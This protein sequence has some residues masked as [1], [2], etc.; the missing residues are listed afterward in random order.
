[1]LI[2][3]PAFNPAKEVAAPK[4]T[5]GL[6][7][8]FTAAVLSFTDQ[9]Q[10]KCVSVDCHVPYE[11]K[12]IPLHEI[13]LPELTGSQSLVVIIMGMR[14]YRS[15]ENVIDQMRWKLMVVVGSFYN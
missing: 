6:Q 5:T 11:D 9:A 4:G 14:Y 3:L 10:N 15:D 12:M 7:L 8:T 2:E 13:I 1:M